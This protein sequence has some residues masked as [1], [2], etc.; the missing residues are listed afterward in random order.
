VK[1]D[2]EKCVSCGQCEKVCNF[3]AVEVRDGQRVYDEVACV[4]C[5]LCVEHCPEGA[6]TLVFEEKGGYFPLDIDLVK[7]K[8]G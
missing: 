2:A 5:E 3:G 1:C 4:G 7:E 8:L 6:L